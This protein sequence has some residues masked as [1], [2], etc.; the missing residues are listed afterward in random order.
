MYY[1]ILRRFRKRNDLGGGGMNK[2][3]K[4]KAYMS[5][6]GIIQA[7]V[8]K[9]I[10]VSNATL[11]KKI[12]GTGSDFSLTEVR[13]ITRHYNISAEEFFINNLVSK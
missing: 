3:Y 4:F 6:K 12:N 9:L 5:E 7:E 13:T 10:E 11:N 8:A 2:Y 1:D